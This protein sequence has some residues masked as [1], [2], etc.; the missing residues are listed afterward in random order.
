M[1]AIKKISFLVP[2]GT[3]LAQRPQGGNSGNGAAA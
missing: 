3:A 1:A 2:H